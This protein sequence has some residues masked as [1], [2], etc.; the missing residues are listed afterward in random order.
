MSVHQ[1][2]RLKNLL[3]SSPA[4]VGHPLTVQAVEQL[5]QYYA[6]VLK[7][8]PQLHLTTLTEPAEF[9]HR[10][11]CE[12]IFL[13]QYLAADVTEVWDVGSGLGIPGVPLA[14]L[15]PDLRV[16][17]VEANGRKAV[18][19]DEVAFAVGLPKLK[20]FNQRLE[21]LSLLPDCAAITARAV[22]K[23]TALLPVILALGR[24]CRQILLLGGLGLAEELGKLPFGFEIEAVLLPGS[25]ASFL[26]S[27]RR[28][29]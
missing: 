7:W 19:L 9:F 4:I 26:I 17:L 27:L 8:N 5:V 24:H 22:E 14:V 15:R 6:L 23:M 3:L 16:H 1:A 10:H 2:E 18:F 20:V 12:A 11:L 13:T 28:F 21:S 29:T 25:Q